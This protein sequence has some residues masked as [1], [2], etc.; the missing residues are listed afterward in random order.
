[1]AGTVGDNSGVG[2]KNF[3]KNAARF[4]TGL[5]LL[6]IP[7]V[8]A[9]LAACA[10]TGHAPKKKARSKE[11]F[12][13]SE[14]GVKASPRV[15]EDGQAVPKGGG[16]YQVGKAYQVRGKWYQPKEE[17]GYNKT[18]LAS[19]YGSA[20]HGRRTANGEVYDL[21]HLSA[22]HPTF[23]LPS[24]ARV[25]NLENGTSVIVRVNDR[26]PFHENRIIDLSYAAAVKIGVWP[27]GTGL[28]EVRAIDPAHADERL[29]PST[30]AVAPARA[31]AATVATPPPASPSNRPTSSSTA[32]LAER[33][34][35]AKPLPVGTARIYLQLGAYGDRANAER[36]M[37][38]AQRAGLGDLAIVSVAI[39]GRTI[40]R[41]RLGPL[42]DADAADAMTR[43]VQRL[44]LGTPRVAIER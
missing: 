42:A 26:G 34:I 28:V 16:R 17:P 20:F 41:V 6:V 8:C 32:A 44:G 29:S 25:T 43:R 7:L 13:E 12:S 38:G 1:M 4:G 30:V 35:D 5:R 40:H 23:P 27:K 10:T 31:S 18:G 11:F 22:A 33:A 39:A 14:Y 19:W 21:Y 2:Y 24:Y 9:G 36:A 37:L 15:V 3:D